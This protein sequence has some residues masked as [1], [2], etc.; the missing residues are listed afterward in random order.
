MYNQ[1]PLTSGSYPKGNGL[2]HCV[3]FEKLKFI[4]LTIDTYSGFQWATAFS[5][6]KV[7]SV[8]THLLEVM[9]IMG[10]PV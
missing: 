5:S 4:H 6:E 7:D 8:I 2:F 1:T 9:A 10:I 3:E